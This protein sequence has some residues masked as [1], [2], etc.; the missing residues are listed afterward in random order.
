LQQDLLGSLKLINKEY[1]A[2][3]KIFKTDKPDKKIIID[4]GWFEYYGKKNAKTVL[5][6]M[7]SMCGTIKEAIDEVSGDVAILKI[8][9]FRPFPGEEIRRVVKNAK[10]I[11]ILEKAL[12]LGAQAPLFSDMSSALY[13]EKTKLVSHVIGLGGEDITEKQ[14]IKIIKA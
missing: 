14:I 7:G 13:G 1:L 5:V 2:W 10:K 8:R 3:K 9:C 4:N 12:S 6:A 11:I